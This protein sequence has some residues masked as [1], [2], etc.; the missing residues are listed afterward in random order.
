MS[1]RTSSTAAPSIQ[2]NKKAKATT[3]QAVLDTYFRSVSNPYPSRQ[4]SPTESHQ[5]PI[6]APPG[7]LG[8]HESLSAVIVDGQFT[9]REARVE[10]WRPGMPQGLERAHDGDGTREKPIRVDSDED[11]R[12]EVNNFA[13]QEPAAGSSR[14]PPLAPFP[15]PTEDRRTNDK[16]TR[17]DADDDHHTEVNHF[18]GQ[19]PAAGSSRLSPLAP[20]SAPTDDRQQSPPTNYSPVVTDPL[21]Y[22]IDS[23]PWSIGSPAPYS[24]L[25]KTLVAL[26]ETRSRIAILNALTNTLR[27]LLLYHPASLLPALYL[28]SNSLSPP[29]SPIELGIGASVIS[30]VI[31]HVS[32]LTPA[33]LRRLYNSSGDPG[34]VAFEAK[35]NVRTLVPHPPLLIKAVYESLL[36]I[37]HVKGQGAAKSKQ[38]MVERL[39]VAAKGEETRYLV[40]TLSMNLRVGAV[41]TSMLTALARALVLTPP[42]NPSL[43][44]P[45]NSPYHATPQF[46]SSIK[47]LSDNN[48][49]AVDA[50]RNQLMMKFARAEAL[51]KQVYVQ[52]PNYD[53]IIAGVL[54]GIPLHPTLG[55]PTRSLDEIYDRLNETLFTVEFK[56]D[57]QRAQI[58]ATRV[59]NGY[60]SVHM[61]SRHLEDMTA[62]YPDVVSLVRHMF[63]Q[64]SNMQSF[65]MDSEIV[66]I[67]P[68]DGTLRSFQ[69]LSNRAKKD[70]EI[71]DIKVPV[72]VFA[73]DLM[74]LD[75]EVLLERPFRERRALLKTR[76]PALTSQDSGTAR[77][78]H[79]ESCESERGRECIEK[80]WQKGRLMVKLLDSGEIWEDVPRQKGKIQKK[81]LPATYEPDKRTSAWLKLKKDYV[82]G[83]GDTLDLVPVGAWHGNGRKAGWWSPLLLA[84]WDPTKE[85]LVAVCKCMSGKVGFLWRD[86][87]SRYA[88]GSDRCSYQP[89]WD[90]ETGGF[91]PDVYF[92]PHEV[93]EI[94][95]A[96][97]TLSPVSLAALGEVSAA[98]GLSLRFP[99]F[100]RVREDKDIEQAS[101]SNFLAQM[102]RDQQGRGKDT[103]GADSGDLVDRE[104][105]DEPAEEDSDN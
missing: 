79:V 100:V 10:R 12:A 17:L 24:F 90:C 51:V 92:R 20:S 44:I 4:P 25:V 37:A 36:K 68:T 63:E 21:V 57:G 46:V 31:Q 1:K 11:H 98:R 73:F 66:A 55:S 54:E 59:G 14:L 6:N 23:C 40:R 42:S 53:H 35:S 30:K 32:G 78:A 22:P 67:D 58:H 103:T 3:N 77:L 72:C 49:K 38:S 8:S 99:R 26:S 74:Y 69:E 81:R 85:T 47:P 104:L 15:A 89:L 48:K 33:A 18:A 27:C 56:Y 52:H 43:L 75:G 94:R 91:K 86:L 61:F 102:Y 87:T 88:L 62:K 70:V 28:L 19:E 7:E 50:Q 41:R 60:P 34:D 96:D 95:G 2:R 105:E 16:P 84:V 76:F 71:Q 83:L 80:F 39:L 93:W 9:L 5:K 29:Y 45:V 101:T 13:G 65:I 97:V 82:H 64:T